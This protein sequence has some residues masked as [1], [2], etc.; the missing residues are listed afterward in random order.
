MSRIE[1]STQTWDSPFWVPCSEER[2][3]QLCAKVLAA[4]NEVSLEK[5]LSE[6]QDATKDYLQNTNGGTQTLR[7][8]DEAA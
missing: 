7:S 4:Q 8:D 3:R 2:V 5:A 6:L 1:Q